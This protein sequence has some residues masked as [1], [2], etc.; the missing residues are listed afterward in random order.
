MLAISS[1]PIYGANIRRKNSKHLHTNSQSRSRSTFNNG[2]APEGSI[3]NETAAAMKSP[4][5]N[6][7]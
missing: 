2:E 6:V 1:T 4:C 5:T 7:I 3:G